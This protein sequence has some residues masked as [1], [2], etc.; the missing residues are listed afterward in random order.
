MKKTLFLLL[1]ICI[2]CMGKSQSPIT[3]NSDSLLFSFSVMEK[4]GVNI[5]DW[6]SIFE[7]NCVL[8][9]LE[10]SVDSINWSNIDSHIGSGTTQS[11]M[12]YSTIHL[13]YKI[14]YNYYRLLQYDFNGYVEIIDTIS[15]D[16][17][18]RK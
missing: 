9:E 11:E 14:G 7:N 5:L 13:G 15:I 17:N 1:F 2:F 3:E 4:D 18:I 12:S 16:N 10:W 8:Y 6:T